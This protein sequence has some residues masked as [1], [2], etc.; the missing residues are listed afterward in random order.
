MTLQ[1]NLTS[2]AVRV[3]TEFNTLRSEIKDAAGVKIEDLSTNSSTTTWSVNRIKQEIENNKQDLE[4]Y[5]KTE[6]LASYVTSTSLSDYQ[7]KTEA[8]KINDVSPSVSSV[9]SSSKVDSQIQA[10]VDKI[11]DGA[12]QALD[13]LKEIATKLQDGS[14]TSAITA[15]LA[16]IGDT[17]HNFVNDFEGALSS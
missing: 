4:P 7:K 1:A 13:T 14:I 8:L 10:A 12:P 3:G 6:D 16:E 5:A 15:K 11:V 9:Y 2:L 17:N